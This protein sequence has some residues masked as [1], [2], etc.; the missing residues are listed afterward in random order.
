MLF[1]ISI[2]VCYAS[3]GCFLSTDSDYYC[4]EL[5]NEQAEK[6]C[7]RIDECDV[8]YQYR[9]GQNCNNL[10]ECKTILC[11]ST[12]EY[13]FAGLCAYE[14]IPEG[15]EEEWCNEGC[16]RFSHLYD[17]FCEVLDNKWKCI[18]KTN[19][20]EVEG[21][22]WNTN[23]D[24]EQCQAQC[25][26]EVPLEQYQLKESS[27]SNII[28]TENEKEETG[29]ILTELFE[30]TED[31]ED[32][33]AGYVNQEESTIPLTSIFFVLFV[34]ALVSAFIYFWHAGKIKLNL[35]SKRSKKNK[36]FDYPIPEEKQET[37]KTNSIFFQ[38]KETSRKLKH[39]R[40]KH[41]VKVH[42]H[43][44]DQTFDQFS[45]KEHTPTSMEKLDHLVKRKERKEQ[46]NTR[47][48]REHILSKVLSKPLYEKPKE[49]RKMNEV[50]HISVMEQLRGIIR[51]RKK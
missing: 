43:E 15:E 26:E 44:L 11:Q 25:T 46:R 41:K 50:E 47:K 8:N 45:G 1:L 32:S 14:K 3:T 39:L 19:G 16:C 28:S 21:F 5:S 18:H 30:D 22:N 24:K 17:D 31:E 12:C 51:K 48:V 10:E 49:K 37:K 7:N 42:E 34:I 40:R 33:Y 23:L 36:K 6:E 27:F 20:I 13:T 38:P 9:E 35:T 4:Q 2:S 29:N